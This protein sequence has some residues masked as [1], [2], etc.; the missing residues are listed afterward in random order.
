[1]PNELG[2]VEAR[3]STDLAANANA[4][5]H[6]KLTTMAN[7]VVRQRQ[8]TGQEEAS[9]DGGEKS[10]EGHPGGAVKHGGGIQLLRLL[11]FMVYTMGS[12]FS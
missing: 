8:K 7:D 12:S 5:V 4:A 6:R 3:K 10:V 2:Y 1:L 11:L 9:S